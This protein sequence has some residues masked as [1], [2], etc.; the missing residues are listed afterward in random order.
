M[1]TESTSFSAL[2]TARLAGVLYLLVVPLGIFSLNVNQKIIVP[3]NPAATAENIAASESLFRLGA[4]SD[5]AAAVTMLLVALTLYLLFKPVSQQA[6]RSMVAFLMVGVPISLLNKLNMFA[7]LNLAKGASFL[8]AIPSEQAQALMYLFIRLSGVG[9][10]IAF[11]FWGLWLLPL[12]YLV[13]KSGFIPK[14]LG[15]LLVVSC[16]GYLIDSAASLLGSPVNIGMVSAAGEVLFILWLLV[17]G[18]D[19]EKYKQA[20]FE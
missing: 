1:K 19:I 11:I 20:A 5:M 16:L 6:A 8:E 18:I 9:G 4:L 15:V 2:F 10:S 17:K 12:G 7:A 3:G 13:Y 14:L